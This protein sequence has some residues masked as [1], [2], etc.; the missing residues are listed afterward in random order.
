MVFYIGRPFFYY[1]IWAISNLYYGII[2][3]LTALLTGL[4]V[5]FVT[6]SNKPAESDPRYFV[7]LVDGECFPKKVHIF[8]RFGVPEE[9]EVTRNTEHQQQELVKLN[10]IKMKEDVSEDSSINEQDSCCANGGKQT[11]CC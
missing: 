4:I 9:M 6:G 1:N 5:S 2:G 11:S 7:P 8:F 3:F 10:D